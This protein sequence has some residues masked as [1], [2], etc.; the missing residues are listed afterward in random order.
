MT[1]N[2]S[3]PLLLPE[4]A[5]QVASLS[6]NRERLGLAYTCRQLFGSVIPF[7]WESLRGVKPIMSLIP[8][9]KFVEEPIV[10]E[11]G[12]VHDVI[13]HI[14]IGQNAL[15]EDWTRYW[16][17]A[18]F[19]KN[20]APF[21]SYKRSYGE[22]L[23]VQGWRFLFMKLNGVTLLPNLR[24]VDVERHNLSSCFDQLAWFALLLSP[25]LQFWYLG[26][27]QWDY[28]SHDLPIPFNLLFGAISRYYSGNSSHTMPKRDEWYPSER[29]LTSICPNEYQEGLSWFVSTPAPINLR[30]LEIP[31]SPLTNVLWDELYTL[32]CLPFLEALVICFAYAHDEAEHKFRNSKGPLPSNMFP[33]LQ[34]LRLTMIP[35]VSLFR[36]IWELKPL[37]S[38]LSS[39][40]IGGWEIGFDCETFASIVVQL[41]HKNSPNLVEFGCGFRVDSE[42]VEL[43]QAAYELLSVMPIKTLVLDGVD[44]GSFPPD[45]SE[46]TFPHLRHLQLQA[47]YHA[48]G[49]STYPKIA[50]AFPNLEYLYID[51]LSYPNR[52]DPSNMNLEHTSF[53]SIEI[54]IPGIRLSNK[55]LDESTRK[56]RW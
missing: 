7:I 27:I 18:P 29:A 53:Q 13:T 14:I 15:T 23:R 19:V 55:K 40:H 46:N 33:C 48:A 24:S 20:I 54:Y 49:C 3:N 47:E 43:L 41:L 5:Q 31:L 4:I 39:T 30:Y 26:I 16:F 10:S 25:S 42:G 32:G 6:E 17:Y 11:Y 36:W 12:S 8:G 38:G 52:C 45:Y 37:V 2:V 21:V 56:F 22:T 35:N 28:D 50:K 34:N 44:I 9:V 1:S 51:P